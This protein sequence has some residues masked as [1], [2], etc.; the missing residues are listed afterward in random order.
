MIYFFD[1]NSATMCAYKSAA[2]KGTEINFENQQLVDELQ[3]TIIRKCQKF[4]I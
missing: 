3:K 4:K 1:K 2:H